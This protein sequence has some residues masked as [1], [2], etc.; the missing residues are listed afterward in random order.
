[1][2]GNPLPTCPTVRGFIIQRSKI[3][4]LYVFFVGCRIPQS[5]SSSSIPWCAHVKAI[6]P[7]FR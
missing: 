3:G 4:V 5:S 2:I 7:S 6:I 1:M